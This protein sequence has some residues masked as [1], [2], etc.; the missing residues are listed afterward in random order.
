MQLSDKH[1]LPI[2]EIGYWSEIKLEIIKKYAKAYST[3]LSKQKGLQHVYIDAFAG[4]GIHISKTSKEFVP[5]SPLNALLVEPPFNEYF[6]IDLDCRKIENLR[7]ISK[8]RRNV[9]IFEGD[10]NE[11][12]LKDIF[13]KVKYDDY[14]RGLCLLDPYGMQINWKVIETAG[15]MGSIEIFLNFPI[16]AINRN[17]LRRIP[18]S[19]SESSIQRMNDL[20]GDDTWRNVAY[21]KEQTLFGFDDIKEPSIKIVN[22]FKERLKKVAFFE[23]VPEPLPMRNTRGA[24]VYY[25]FF[26]SPK[27]TA[28]KIILDIFKRYRNRGLNNG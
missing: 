12:L 17:V 1:G 19:A 23:Y 13:P 20:W 15:K 7:E 3:I 16:M 4:T 9:H 14:R 11:K 5:G 21:I 18:D 25:L 24:I 26:A 28:N 8:E 22:A 6:F 2:D 27:A 10:C